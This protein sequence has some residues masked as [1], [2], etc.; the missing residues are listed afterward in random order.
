MS[1]TQPTRREFAAT[2]ASGAVGMLAACAHPAHL[3]SPLPAPASAPVGAASAPPTAAD[4][5]HAPDP[6]APQAD[7][8]LSVVVARY[9]ASIPDAERADVRRGIRGNM[10][11]ADR[12][13]GTPLM[14]AIDPFSSFVPAP[15]SGGHP[16]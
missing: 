1:V 4:S 2:L 6:A 7:A 16:R 12:L 15:T 9:G 8:L 14:N 10:R 11:L 13:R 5:T 3:P